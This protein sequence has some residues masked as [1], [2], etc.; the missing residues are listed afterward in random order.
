[1]CA[2]ADACTDDVMCAYVCLLACVMCLVAVWCVVCTFFFLMN[3]TFT[4]WGRTSLFRVIVAFILF[5]LFWRCNMRH[6]SV[7]T[8]L[9][10]LQNDVFS[11]FLSLSLSSV[12]ASLPYI[13][14]TN[15]DWR[16]WRRRRRQWRLLCERHRKRRYCQCACLW[17]A[18]KKY[19]LFDCIP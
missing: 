9:S 19:L 17:I 18:G 14:H 13:F 11:F 10:D 8:Y 7:Q 4:Y 2:D 1:M 5:A 6:V 3:L 15:L 12:T 16:W